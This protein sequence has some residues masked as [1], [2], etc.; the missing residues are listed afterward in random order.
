MSDRLHIV[1]ASP[2]GVALDRVAIPHGGQL[3][4][5]APPSELATFLDADGRVVTALEALVVYELPPSSADSNDPRTAEELPF[6]SRVL[7]ALLGGLERTIRQLERRS[8]R[9]AQ[10]PTPLLASLVTGHGPRLHLE[11]VLHA[12]HL[13]GRI[14]PE[15]SAA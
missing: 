5:T 9:R 13:P 7:L 4:V 15:G 8:R 12:D 1:I 10:G 11:H 3:V 14:V 2:E 6:V